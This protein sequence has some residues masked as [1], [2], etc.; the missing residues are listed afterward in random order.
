MNSKSFYKEAFK[1]DVTDKAYVIPKKLKNASM[2]IC[3]AY[4]IKGICDPMYIVN[5]MAR[6]LGLGDGRSKFYTPKITL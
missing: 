3:N 1:N 5:V 2:R 4:G 6:E